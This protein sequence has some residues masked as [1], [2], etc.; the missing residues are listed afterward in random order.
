MDNLKNDSNELTNNRYYQRL[1]RIE[2]KIDKLSDAV[3]AIA[4]V[5]E[6]IVAIEGEKQDYWNRLNNHALKIDE[7][8]VDI[9]KVDARSEML[10]RLHTRDKE[11]CHVR[12]QELAERISTVEKSVDMIE[13]SV[14]GIE[15]TT[16]VLHRLAWASVAV[17]LA[18]IGNYFTGL[19]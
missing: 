14:E 7:H 19:I 2:E 8:E 1:D 16:L 17:G 5:E 6:K 4:R 10:E 3:I 11:D 9:T 12:Q 15:R 13:K 18:I